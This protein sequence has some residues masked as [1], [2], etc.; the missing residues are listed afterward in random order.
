MEALARIVD[1]RFAV[2]MAI[3]GVAGGYLGARFYGACPSHLRAPNVIAT[4]RD[5]DNAVLRQDFR[6]LTYCLEGKSSELSVV[7]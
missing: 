5:D 2:P 3:I 6:D 1:W 7:R 4:R